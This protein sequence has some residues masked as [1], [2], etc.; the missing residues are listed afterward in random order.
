MYSEKYAVVENPEGPVFVAVTTE[1]NPYRRLCEPVSLE[2]AVSLDRDASL[3]RFCCTLDG[4]VAFM[5][6]AMFL[7][8][9]ALLPLLA[10]VWGYE[11]TQTYN[12]KML[13]S[14]LVYQH[15]Y[16]LARWALLGYALWHNF[17]M[18][19]EDDCRYWILMSILPIIQTYITWRVHRFYNTLR[20]IYINTA[21]YSDV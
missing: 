5:N 11:G 4:V 16:T 15:L 1:H 8:P 7:N 2:S 14:Y 20:G 3:V 6:L 18:N 10:S 17:E 13:I 21:A 12:Y 19:T 9:I